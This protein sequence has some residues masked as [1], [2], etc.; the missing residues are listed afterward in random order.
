MQFDGEGRTRRNRSYVTALIPAFLLF[1]AIQCAGISKDG[2]DLTVHEKRPMLIGRVTD[3]NLKPLG[4]VQ[5]KVTSPDSKL[6]ISTDTKDDGSFQIAHDPCKIC[7]LE[8]FPPKGSNLAPARLD[9]LPGDTTRRL[10]IE[11]KEGFEISGRILGNGKGLKGLAISIVPANDQSSKPSSIH[12]SAS[13]TTD[14][15]GSFSMLVTPGA[16]KVTIANDRYPRFTKSFS[17]Q[18]DVTAG[19]GIADISLP[20]SEPSKMLP[21]G[22]PAR[23]EM[24]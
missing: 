23:L 5:L 24:Y 21:G 9:N 7:A 11:L 1:A 17:T 6:K 16:K 10:V 3:A 20:A 13:A 14:K 15:A 22:G 8:A 19:G 4:S 2:F 18:I 12:G